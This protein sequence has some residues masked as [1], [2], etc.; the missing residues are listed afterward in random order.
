[1]LQAPGPAVGS[2]ATAHA[3][4]ASTNSAARAL[5]SGSEQATS[6]AGDKGVGASVEAVGWTY[7]ALAWRLW[8]WLLLLWLRLWL[9]WLWR[10]WLWRRLVLLVLLRWLQSCRQV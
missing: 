2:A 6:L 8:L 1:M 7:A 5:T 3:H 4:V 9:L 10:R